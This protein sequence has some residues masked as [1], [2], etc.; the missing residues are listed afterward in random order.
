MNIFK[1][2][3]LIEKIEKLRN[4]GWLVVLKCQ[5]KEL[6]W[7]IQGAASEY[8]APSDDTKIG[9]GMWCAEA[10][11]FGG[12]SISL[13]PFALAPTADE[14]VEKIIGECEEIEERVKK[15]AIK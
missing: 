7:I 11:W 14:A 9:K 10:H 3:S 13:S 8:D 15:N 12:N 6:E 5:P 2:H 4:R 1:K